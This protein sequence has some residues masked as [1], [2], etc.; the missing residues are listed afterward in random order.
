MCTAAAKQKQTTIK[1]KIAVGVVEAGAALLKDAPVEPP[2]DAANVVTRLVHVPPEM[3][4]GLSVHGWVAKVIK[5]SLQRPA[6]CRLKLHDGTYDFTLES[7]LALK[8]LS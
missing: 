4:P 5:C 3:W 6:S 1:Y 7:V 2:L 8:P